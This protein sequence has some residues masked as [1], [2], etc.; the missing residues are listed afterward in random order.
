MKYRVLHRAEDHQGVEDQDAR[1]T[2]CG[3]ETP[4]GFVQESTGELAAA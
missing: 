4:P 1:G 3:S 2:G